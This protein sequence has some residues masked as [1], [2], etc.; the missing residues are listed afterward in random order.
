[1]QTRRAFLF[2]GLVNL[3]TFAAS[4]ALIAFAEDLIS[5]DGVTALKQTVADIFKSRPFVEA[6]TY[7]ISSEITEYDTAYFYEI[8]FV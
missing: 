1:M 2:D 5:D 4:G 8:I 6:L 3:T 7:A